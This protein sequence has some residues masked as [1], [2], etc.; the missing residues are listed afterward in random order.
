MAKARST[1]VLSGPSQNSFSWETTFPTIPYYLLS[2]GSSIASGICVYSL[3][4]SSLSLVRESTPFGLTLILICSSWFLGVIP[5]GVTLLL[6]L[7]EPIVNFAER[8]VMRLNRGLQVAIQA[9]KMPTQSSTVEQKPP[10][11]SSPRRTLLAIWDMWLVVGSECR[12]NAARKL[13][14]L[15]TRVRRVTDIFDKEETDD[16]DNARTIE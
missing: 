10:G 2:T 1:I 3:S 8:F 16:T 14:G 11:I 5:R 15:T 9:A 13:V 4:L 6:L 12:T 7:P